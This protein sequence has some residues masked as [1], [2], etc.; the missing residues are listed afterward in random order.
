MRRLWCWLALV[1]L[2]VGGAR[3]LLKYAWW[4]AVHGAL[5]GIPKGTRRLQE[6]D[7][8]ADFN[9]WVLMGLAG[10]AT[11]VASILIPPL[12]SQ[13]LPTGLKGISRFLFALVLVVGSILIVAAGMSATGYFLK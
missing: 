13:T 8:N 11:I 3:A 9:W 4:A 2:V 1:P 10:T 7:A 12:K 6:A 5:Y